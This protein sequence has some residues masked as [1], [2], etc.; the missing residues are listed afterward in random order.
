MGLNLE[1]G[2]AIAIEEIN[3]AGG[4]TVKGERYLVKYIVGDHKQGLQITFWQITVMI[5]KDNIKYIV[6][7]CVGAPAA[8]LSRLPNDHVVFYISVG[9]EEYR[10]DKPY[11]FRTLVSQWKLPTIIWMVP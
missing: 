7:N 5:F 6:G 3:E 11:S 8:A 1:H 10:S 2:L 9:H 4:I